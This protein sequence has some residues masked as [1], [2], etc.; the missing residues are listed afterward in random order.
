MRSQHRLVAFMLLLGTAAAASAQTTGRA[1]TFAAQLGTMQT[2]SANSASTYAFKAAPPLGRMAQDPLGDE[3]FS[4]RYADLQAE[5][6]NSS[7]FEPA[8]TLTRIAADPV[9]HESFGDRF[10][11]MQ[12]ASSNSGE[13]GFRPGAD[14]A[15]AL[16]N[17]M[18]VE[19]GS[20]RSAAKMPVNGAT[21]TNVVAAQN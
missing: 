8:P 5:S 16:A 3:P 14:V 6:S 10:A 15:S 20:L 9:R 21:D 11:Q 7:N 13:Y 19:A 4:E 18:T 2:L 12:A 17:N 1:Q